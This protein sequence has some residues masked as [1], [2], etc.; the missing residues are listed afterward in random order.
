MNL[1]KQTGRVTAVMLLN[2]VATWS[3]GRG[4]AELRRG[5]RIPTVKPVLGLSKL[6]IVSWRA[7]ANRAVP[8]IL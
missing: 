8:T 3:L 4:M 1:A 7:C 2:P 6:I 5:G